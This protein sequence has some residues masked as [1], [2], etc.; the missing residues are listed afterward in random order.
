[1]ASKSG[2]KS[3][4]GGMSKYHRASVEL[5]KSSGLSSPTAIL[6]KFSEQTSESAELK[7][8]KSINERKLLEL[9]E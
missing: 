8:Q 1:M 9:T 2:G 6:V 3:G 4:S 5:L 7:D